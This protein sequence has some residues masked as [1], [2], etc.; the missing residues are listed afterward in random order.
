MS[1]SI[2]SLRF[3]VW[4]HSGTCSSAITGRMVYGTL[5]PL[6]PPTLPA[7]VTNSQSVHD[8]RRDPYN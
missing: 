5:I 6:S 3:A 8:R 4:N 7:Q 1:A 2:C